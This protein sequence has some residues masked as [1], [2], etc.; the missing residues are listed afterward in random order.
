MFVEA[1]AQLVAQGAPFDSDV[2]K[3]AHHGSRTSSSDSFLYSV[4]PAAAVISV[5]EGNRFGHPHVD[6][7]EA[8]LQHVPQDLLFLTSERGTIEVVTDGKRLWVKTER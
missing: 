6:T 8:L 4:T 5:S 1:E 3:V 2:L 7:L